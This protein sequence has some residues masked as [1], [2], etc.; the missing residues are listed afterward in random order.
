MT[1]STGMRWGG[2]S[3]RREELNEAGRNAVAASLVERRGAGQDGGFSFEDFEFYRN[4][5]K[6][7]HPY[8]IK[9]G[10]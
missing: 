7:L 4:G 10:Q 6:C 3:T 1:A 9:P 2:L 8:R 5:V